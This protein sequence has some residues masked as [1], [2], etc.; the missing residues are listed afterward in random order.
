MYRARL[1]SLRN[2]L[3]LRFLGSAVLLQLE[4]A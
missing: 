2:R 3:T 1:E 4:G